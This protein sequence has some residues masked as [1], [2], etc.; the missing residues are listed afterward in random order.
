MVCANATNPTPFRAWSAHSCSISSLIHPSPTPIPAMDVPHLEGI[1]MAT[2]KSGRPHYS[3]WHASFLCFCKA[4]WQQHLIVEQDFQTGL[5]LG[6][7]S[8]IGACSALIH[9]GRLGSARALG[10]S[11]CWCHQSCSPPRPDLPTPSSLCSTLPCDV[12]PPLHPWTRLDYSGG[13]LSFHQW[14]Q[15]IP[16][17]CLGLTPQQST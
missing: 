16:R 9:A 8:G 2:G 7:N 15:E 17:A 12:L 11:L 1:P 10:F 13:P 6:C 3:C 14:Q 5:G 4:F